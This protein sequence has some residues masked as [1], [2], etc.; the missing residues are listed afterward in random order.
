MV[1]V[2]VARGQRLGRDLEHPHADL[3]VAD[4]EM[5]G[6]LRRRRAGIVDLRQAVFN[7]KHD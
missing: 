7:V 1:G 4:R 6:S 5:V 2:E 3:G